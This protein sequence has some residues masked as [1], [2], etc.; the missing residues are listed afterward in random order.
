M[1]SESS[2][3]NGEAFNSASANQDHSVKELIDL[4]CSFWSGAEWKDMSMGV[5]LEEAGLL[6]LNCDKV[7][8]T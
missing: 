5:H 6:K 2:V 3:L 8:S 1:L 4:M 7:A